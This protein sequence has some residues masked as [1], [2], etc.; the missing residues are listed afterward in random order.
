MWIRLQEIEDEQAVVW[1]PA[2]LVEA[3]GQSA[4]LQVGCCQRQ[5][6]VRVGGE[7]HPGSGI[8]AEQPLPVSISTGLSRALLLPEG[9]IFRLKHGYGRL[10]IGPIIGLLLGLD[11][12]RYSP[13]SMNKFN[14]RLGVYKQVGGLVCAFSPE[15]IDYDSRIA[16]G[17]Y[18]LPEEGAWKFGRFPLPNVIYRRNFHTGQSTI[19]RLEQLTGGRLFN[20]YRFD[21]AELYAFL[22]GDRDL[23]KFL[24][25]WAKVQEQS[26]VLQF[27]ELHQKIILKPLDL[28]RG[29][30]I[31]ILEVGPAGSLV[32]DYRSPQP[33][34]YDLPDRTGV[35]LFLEQNSGLFDRY[36]MQRYI[37][38]ASVGG[39]PFD[40][41][42]VMQK[43]PWM[44]WDCS[45]I[46]CRIGKNDSLLTNISRG[47]YALTLPRALALAFP[48]HI[49]NPIL[50]RQLVDLALGICRRLDRM[51]EHF[52]E[53]GLDLAVDTDRQIWIIEANVFPSFKGFKRTSHLTY[54]SIRYAPL[55]YALYLSG[56][57]QPEGEG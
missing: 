29:R 42:L 44:S 52:A 1:L 51:G 18:Y 12:H 31:C 13:R 35:Q 34:K 36:L 20:S 28:S 48:G 33:R 27:L 24:P 23:L 57:D 11:T 5:V 15:A 47:G 38:L 21:K 43:R 30:G 41:R 39:A 10:L 25:P 56:L 45:S 4:E 19:R 7:P 22:A 32:Y 6:E 14:D 54:L 53:L 2:Q 17:L 37:R 49:N 55:L 16:S 3:V 50:E 40:I 26:Q 8:V 46:E 9:P